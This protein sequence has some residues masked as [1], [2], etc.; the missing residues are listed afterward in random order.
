V[1]NPVLL[2]AC[3]EDE[4]TLASFREG[5]V[6]RLRGDLNRLRLLHAEGRSDELREAAHTLCGMIVACS[7]RV[8]GVASELEDSAADGDLVRAG[9]LV[10]R[11]EPLVA[12]LCEELRA[13][14]VDGLRAAES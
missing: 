10:A 9:S 11:L 7:T 4:R 1:F 5:L 3:G 8:A 13:A 12:G 14:T 6:P 2:A